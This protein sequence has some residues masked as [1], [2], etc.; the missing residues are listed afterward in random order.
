MYS[1]LILFPVCIYCTCFLANDKVVIDNLHIL[2]TFLSWTVP[3]LTSFPRI[4]SS[5]SSVSSVDQENG[6]NSRYTAW[7][8]L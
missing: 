8:T 6:H 4:F 5:L 1:T 2:F 7:S 3:P